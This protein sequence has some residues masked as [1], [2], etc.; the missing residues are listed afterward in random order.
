MLRCFERQRVTTSNRRLSA[1]LFGNASID[2]FSTYSGSLTQPDVLAEGV[3][4]FVVYKPPN[5][6]VEPNFS[7][8]LASQ[9]SKEPI[10]S[11]RAVYQALLGTDTV[12]F[13]LRLNRN[14]AGLTLGCTDAGMNAQF[15]R[16]LASGEIR[17]HYHVLCH[18]NNS[19]D[20][21][22]GSFKTAS[23]TVES[24]PGDI[25]LVNIV[26]SKLRASDIYEIID[27]RRLVLASST[28]LP[29]SILLSRLSFPEPT[30]PA[31]G[32][33]VTVSMGLP[34]EWSRLLV[35]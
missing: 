7:H 23:I 29:F 21:S 1:R 20:L 12:H 18:L 24:F 26:S 4:W 22:P 31:S 5:W 8:S 15:T 6:L 33:E 14:F 19:S 3:R 16:Q 28:N 27:K 32:D 2:S 9:S 35:C 17:K 34:G 13:P 10:P 30:N 11:L 25:A